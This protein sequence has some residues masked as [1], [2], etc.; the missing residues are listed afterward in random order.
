MR[1]GQDFNFNDLTKAESKTFRILLEKIEKELGDDTF[2]S[3]FSKAHYHGNGGGVGELNLSFP[4]QFVTQYIKDN[5]VEEILKVAKEID[6]KVEQV[7]LI[8]R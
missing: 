7:V 5:F 6:E 1:I 8:K 2:K 3:W 4:S